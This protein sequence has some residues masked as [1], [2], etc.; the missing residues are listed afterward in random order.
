MD[1]NLILALVAGMAVVVFLILKTKVQAFPALLLASI[2]V[3]LVARM[4]TDEIMG[5]ISEGFGS[6]LSSI[7]II[8]GLGVMMGKILEVTGAA[9]KMALSI[10]SIVGEERI[11]WVLML[12]GWLVSIP[13]FC[14]SGFVILSELAREFSRNT[15]KSMVLLGGSLGIG[16]YLTHY[17]VPPT[18]GPLG[19]AGILG[20]DVGNLL[21]YGVLVSGLAMIPTMIYTRYISDKLDPIIP[22]ESEESKCFMEELDQLPSGFLSFLPIIAPIVLI[23]S[24]T[25]LTSLGRQNSAIA[26]VGNPI[27]AVLVGLLISIYTLTKNHTVDEVVCILEESLADAGLILCITGAGGALGA[28]LRVS[29]VGQHVAELIAASPF[30]PILVPML[31]A[32]LLKISQGSGTVAV[33]TSASI[34]APMIDTLGISPLITALAVSAG[35][36]VA[37]FISDS[38]FWVVTRFSGMDVDVGTKAWTSISAVS[39][40]SACV[41]VYILGFFI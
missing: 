14:D 1:T 15:K 25:V 33:I 39:G 7:G 24:N 32:S 27:F 8:I 26:L 16:L 10:L 20:V 2:V 34:L 41:I 11:E 28:I 21:I 40:L 22:E 38:Y 30:P 29:G 5:N 23:L 9:K 6:T 36:M 18:P 4:P 13:V 12:S 19:V 31:M 3:G 17:F 35:G 37:S